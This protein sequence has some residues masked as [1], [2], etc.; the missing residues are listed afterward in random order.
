[1]TNLDKEQ[2]TWLIVTIATVT[3][4]IFIFTGITYAYFTANDNT[5][6]TVQ[7]ITDSSKMIMELMIGQK[8]A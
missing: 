6:S 7:I 5:G 8:Q 4:L 3:I 1:M 2:R